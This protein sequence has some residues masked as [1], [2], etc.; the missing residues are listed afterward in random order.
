MKSVLRR[1]QVVALPATGSGPV[2]QALALATALVLTSPSQASTSD[3]DTSSTSAD[4]ATSNKEK[5]TELDRLQVISQRVN[6][7]NSGGTL[8]D[9][10]VLDTPFSITTVDAEEI[11]MRQ[12]DNIGTLFLADASVG[13]SGSAYTG[14]PSQVMLR[15]LPADFYNS[16]LLNGTPAGFIYGIN[17]PLEFMQEVQLL[18]GATGFMYGFASPGG[19]INYVTKKADGEQ[20]MSADVGYRS[21]NI[22]SEHVDLGGKLF[23]SDIFSYRLNLSNEH[24]QSASGNSI[25]RRAGALAL[26]GKLTP[27]LT[28]HADIMVQ[29]RVLDHPSPYFY[30]YPGTYTGTRLPVAPDG[31]FNMSSDTS[32]IY[33]KFEYYAS[34][35]DWQ[36]S[37]NWKFS[38]NTSHMHSYLLALED[39]TYL[40]NQQGDLMTSTWNGLDIT[41][42]EFTQGMLQG[43]FY[44][45]PLKHDLV[46][47]AS[48]QKQDMRLG[49]MNFSQAESILLYHNLYDP[50]TIVWSEDTSRYVYP[51]L[52]TRQTSGFLNDTISLGEKWSLLAGWRY[53]K[54]NRWAYSTRT[55][56]SDGYYDF[57]YLGYNKY[58]NTPTYALMYKP[59]QQATLYASYVQSLE[60][61]STVGSSY[62]NYGDVLEPIKSEQYEVG[63]K[64][65]EAGWDAS[66]AFY[67]INRGA[68]YVT[69][70]N[71][72]VQDGNIR[73]DGAELGGNLWLTTGLRL[74][75]SLLWLDSSYQKTSNDWLIGK[76]QAG[77]RKL[78]TSLEA[79]YNFEAVPGL[80]VHAVGKY[81]GRGVAY[82][83]TTLETV[84]DAQSYTL[85]NLGVGY[86]MQISG[87]PVTFRAEVENLFNRAYWAVT[88]SYVYLG[89]PRTFA[90]NMKFDL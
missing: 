81:F 32:L 15:G 59:V 67:R 11:Q 6:K 12:A 66:L 21:D 23:G 77:T 86:T 26:Q 29:R 16:L 14:F 44:T 60:P 33:N 58:V 30:I 8:G 18:K 35:V 70:D 34:G 48:Y 64:W 17:L 89:T 73:Y 38:F 19:M 88:P 69:A 1:P 62:K 20:V 5:V 41:N 78:T 65:Q 61:G 2:L 83:N 82:N 43:T 13:S 40:L 76:E 84:V 3:E 31:S 9:R 4:D 27:N 52:V 45:G 72:Y 63:A 68:A 25:D 28:W 55:L 10:S 51:Y 47:G 22:F 46:V 57:T 85:F 37:D 39:F 71:Y 53:I 42:T 50:K 36:I 7:N 80:S 24:G 75:G 54:Y 90:V 56:G 79:L 74:G 49:Q 87:H